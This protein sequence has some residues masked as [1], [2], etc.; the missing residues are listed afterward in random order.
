MSLARWNGRPDNERAGLGGS[1]S[2]ER[3]GHFNPKLFQSE[4][5]RPAPFQDTIT[6]AQIWQ[7]PAQAPIM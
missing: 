7:N 1:L 6:G 4:T 5:G 3:E 2:R